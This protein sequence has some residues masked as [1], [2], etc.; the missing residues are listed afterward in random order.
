MI[1]LFRSR[2]V[3]VDPTLALCETLYTARPRKPAPT[4]GLVLERLPPQVRRKL[5]LGGAP[6]DKDMDRKLRSYS[7]AIVRLTGA[8]YRGGV[9]VVAGSDGVGGFTLHRELELLVQ[10]G[11]RPAEVLRLS[12]LGAAEI[13]KRDRE[14]GAVEVGKRA[15]LV[16]VEGDPLQDISAV[17][18]VSLVMKD[19]V[20]LDSGRLYAAIGVAK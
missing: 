3:V 8:L 15:D 9:R 1:S 12:T 2:Q 5:A 10:A 4:L 14:V 6:V 17:R 16:L 7:E 20:L 18:R 13:M 19:G 11:L